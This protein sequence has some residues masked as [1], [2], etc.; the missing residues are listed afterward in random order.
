MN[1][2]YLKP[3][4]SLLSSLHRAGLV[5]KLAFGLSAENQFNIP[6]IEDLLDELHGEGGIEW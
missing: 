5:F 3:K 1:F 2:T 4:P 6:V